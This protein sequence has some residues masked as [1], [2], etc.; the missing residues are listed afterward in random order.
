MLAFAAAK[1][2]PKAIKKESG[3]PFIEFEWSALTMLEQ[4][5]FR[6]LSEE[7]AALNAMQIYYATILFHGGINTENKQVVKLPFPGVPTSPFITVDAMKKIFSELKTKKI[8]F[9]AHTTIIRK[10]EGFVS[11][12]WVKEREE[13]S[14]KAAK[15]YYLPAEVREKIK[16][17]I[18]P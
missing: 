12:G 14:G 6:V 9:P 3:T 11:I 17:A 4:N 10:L 1:Q 15:L 13:L 2:T 8:K 16:K 18:S 5:M 7:N